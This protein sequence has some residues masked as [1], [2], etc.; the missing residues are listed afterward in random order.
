MFRVNFQRTGASDE[1]GIRQFQGVKWKIKKESTIYF[2]SAPV[3]IDGTLY[4]LNS[5]GYLEALDIQ[6]GQK[7]WE[8][9]LEID[10]LSQLTF[11][12]KIIYIGRKWLY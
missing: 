8:I 6:N 11:N 2:G 7:R 9:F 1:T 10:L 3:I 4:L 12:D 5:A